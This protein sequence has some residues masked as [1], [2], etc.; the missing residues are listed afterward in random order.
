MG[1]LTEDVFR[2]RKIWKTVTFFAY[3]PYKENITIDMTKEEIPF[4]TIVGT[5][6]LDT[7]PEY[8]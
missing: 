4:E 2:V 6:L 7:D 1:E 3:Y 5:G 8:K